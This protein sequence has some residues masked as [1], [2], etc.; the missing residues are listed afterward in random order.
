[1]P[2]DAEAQAAVRDYIDAVPPEHRPLFDRLHHLLLSEHPDAAVTISYRI[3]SYKVGRRRLYLGAWKHGL[4]VYGWQTGRDGG[5]T[6]RHPELV[7]GRGTIRL[8]PADAGQV[9]DEEL[10]ALFRAA[11][12][13]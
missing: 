1:V 6:E 13:A 10:R 7:T 12:G 8:T 4:S 9:D 11:L 2:T 3:P 5:F